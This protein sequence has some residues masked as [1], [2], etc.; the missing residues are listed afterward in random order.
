MEAKI[1]STKTSLKGV[2]NLHNLYELYTKKNNKWQLF[3]I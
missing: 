3:F 2:N 1:E